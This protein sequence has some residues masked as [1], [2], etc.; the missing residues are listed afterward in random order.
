M[1][2]TEGETTVY[3]ER[4]SELQSEVSEVVHCVEKEDMR[5]NLIH[6]YG[7]W[8]TGSHVWDHIRVLCGCTLWGMVGVAG[9]K[10]RMVGCA[11]AWKVLGCYIEECGHKA[12]RLSQVP[13]RW[14]RLRQSL[15]ELN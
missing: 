3:T 9:E 8:E 10:S 7:G 15:V 14:Q 4:G 2:G 5:G 11:G 13:S 6:N 12:P 1:L